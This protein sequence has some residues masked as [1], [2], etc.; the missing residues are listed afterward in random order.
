M[1]ATLAGTSPA[2]L[3]AVSAYARGGEQ[4]DPHALD[5]HLATVAE[6]AACSLIRDRFRTGFQHAAYHELLSAVAA[7]RSVLGFS[8]SPTARE[9]MEWQDQQRAAHTTAFRSVK[10]PYAVRFVDG[11]YRGVEMAIDG[12]T[13]PYPDPVDPLGYLA[14][15]RWIAGPPPF[16]VFP[17][18]WGDT[19]HPGHGS[20]RYW[21]QDEPDR[22]GMWLF[23]LRT[24]DPAPPEGARPH[25]TVP[26]G[27]GDR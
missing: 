20:V 12:P 19:E 8:P 25:I 22:D 1:T 4:V 26:A 18:V 16:V 5:L 21:R 9:V 17:I 15:G 24:D 23:H 14:S 3:A 7:L 10:R 6:K 13:V 11:P 27:K 2:I